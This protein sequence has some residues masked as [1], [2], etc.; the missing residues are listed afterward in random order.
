MVLLAKDKPVDVTKYKLEADGSFKRPETAFRSFIEKGGRF[1][2]EADRY[3]LYV[4]LGCPWATRTLIVRKL[5]GLENII[6]VTVV[7]PRMGTS[8][9]AFG[10]ID[11][12]PGADADTLYGSEHVKDLYFKVDPDFQGRFTV[13]I[14]WDKKTHTIVNNESA[15]I[16]RIFNTAFNDLPPTDSRAATVDLYPQELRTE[17]D[18]INA[19]VYEKI[20]NGVYRVGLVQAQTA[21]ENAVREL[22][23]AL[24][25]VE[26]ML[27]GRH[28]LVGDRLTEADV[29]LF[30]TVI[31]FD[32]VYVGHFKCNIQTIR[33]GYPAIH[34][35]MQKLYW[36]DDAFRSTTDFDHIKTHYYWSHTFVSCPL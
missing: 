17:I 10:D 33:D 11:A 25:E 34:K 3:H 16:V 6:S 14:L 36:N 31:R 26:R 15:E 9:W 20:N 23:G 12:F 7:S 30:V 22:F 28:F 21:Y 5:K 13:P 8:G 19:L 4:S 35:W 32:P 18:K 1:E 29:R 2:P 24:D 27:D